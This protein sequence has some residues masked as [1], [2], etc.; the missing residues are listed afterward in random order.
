MSATKRAP[1]GK[2]TGSEYYVLEAPDS[3]LFRFDQ[4]TMQK[5]AKRLRHL[6]AEVARLHRESRKDTPNAP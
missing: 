2:L 6:E 3:L 1:V 5:A 4:K